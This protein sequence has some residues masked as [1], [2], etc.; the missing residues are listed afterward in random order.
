MNANPDSP[1]RQGRPAGG[2]VLNTLF[3]SKTR[4]CVDFWTKMTYEDQD[5]FEC[6]KAALAA[7]WRRYRD[8]GV[9]PVSFAPLAASA[10]RA[11]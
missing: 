1:E 2:K 8:T 7:A 6:D 3:S 10:E 4:F 5:R 9:P 11:E